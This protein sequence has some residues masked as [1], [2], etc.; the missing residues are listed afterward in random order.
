MWSRN[1]SFSGFF[2]AW[3]DHRCCLGKFGSWPIPLKKKKKGKE[4]KIPLIPQISQN[5]TCLGWGLC[6]LQSEQA[7][8]TPGSS[9]NKSCWCLSLLRSLF[10]THVLPHCL[11]H[12]GVPRWKQQKQGNEKQSPLLVP[13]YLGM[14]QGKR[15][16]HT[17]WALNL[18]SLLG[19]RGAEWASPRAA[20][21]K[22]ILEQAER[23]TAHTIYRGSKRKWLLLTVFLKG[24]YPGGE[25]VALFVKT[26]V[27]FPGPLAIL[28]LSRFSIIQFN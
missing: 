10:P 19:C 27:N 6:Q 2:Q 12:C 9:N 8:E 28:F 16:A 1:N 11:S 20:K 21:T 17:N 15:M 24:I 3:M 18:R 13:V 5:S 23:Q 7:S 14:A 22:Q 4:S 26:V 25:S